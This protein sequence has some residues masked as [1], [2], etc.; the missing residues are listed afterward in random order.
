MDSHGF[1]MKMYYPLE[2]EEVIARMPEVAEVCVF[3]I[4]NE[5]DGD[6]AAASV[7]AKAGCQLT[8]N[9]VL[10][11][12]AENISEDYKQLHA[13]VQIVSNLAKNLNGKVK[14]H[15]VKEEFLKATGQI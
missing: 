4:W 9:Q 14:R 15:T 7:V 13:G 6:A 11:F 10:E 12:V 3:G 2:I 8:A 1:S 5:I